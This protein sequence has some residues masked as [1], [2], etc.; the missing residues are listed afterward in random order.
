MDTQTLFIPPPNLACLRAGTKGEAKR[1]VWD[2][3][4]AQ[5]ISQAVSWA[6]KNPVLTAP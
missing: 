4:E 3:N 1:L 2:Q 6:H 5:T